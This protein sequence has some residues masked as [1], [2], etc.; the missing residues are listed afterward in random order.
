[1][2]LEIIGLITLSILFYALVTGFFAYSVE[3]SED[4]LLCAWITGGML[5]V[6][7]VLLWAAVPCPFAIM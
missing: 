4:E 1:M 6:V 7:T 2:V 3:V 5:F